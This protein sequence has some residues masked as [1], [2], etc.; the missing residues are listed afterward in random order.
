MFDF[1]PFIHKQSESESE[2]LPK[3]FD[4]AN[5]KVA[6][7]RSLMRWTGLRPGGEGTWARLSWRGY[8]PPSRTSLQRRLRQKCRFYKKKSLM[9]ALEQHASVSCGRANFSKCKPHLIHFLQEKLETSTC[10]R[11]CLDPLSF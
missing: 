8:E 9:Q 5:V 2:S 10:L 7:E 4:K 6:R 3:P 11:S 1:Q